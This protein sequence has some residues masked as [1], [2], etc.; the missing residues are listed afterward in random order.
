[1]TLEGAT[2]IDTALKG[3][4]GTIVSVDLESFDVAVS[5]RIGQV[6]GLRLAD[7]AAGRY[8]VEEHMP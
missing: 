6:T 3:R 5:W 4:R 1:M 7:I 8:Q 2:I